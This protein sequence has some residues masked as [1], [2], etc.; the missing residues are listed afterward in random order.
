M[1]SSEPSNITAPDAGRDA[2][3]EKLIKACEDLTYVSETDAP[4]QPFVPEEGSLDELAAAIKEKSS[5]PVKRITLREFFANPTRE[6]N[7]HNKKQ[8][9]SVR[10]FV[11]LRELLEENLTDPVCFRAGR[12][13]IDIF[14]VGID[15]S[16]RLAGIRTYAVE[17]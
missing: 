17:T 12:V 1:Q 4:V 11:Q 6:R 5:G 9:E 16:G 3:R 7:W 10:R 13:Q 8:K 15:G 2:F 14:V